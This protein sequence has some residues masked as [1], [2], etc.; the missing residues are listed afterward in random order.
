MKTEHFV[1]VIIE[2]KDDLPQQEGTYTVNGGYEIEFHLPG[3]WYRKESGC[4][5][6]WN[7]FIW[8]LLP[9]QSQQITCKSCNEPISEYCNR[10]KHLW[11]T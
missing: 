2:S 7:H 9:E 3:I 4:I 6:A 10:C 5:Y 8:Y 11:K 1:K